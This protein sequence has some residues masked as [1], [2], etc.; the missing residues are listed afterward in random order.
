MVLR[1]EVLKPWLVTS[2]PYEH[3]FCNMRRV[4]REFTCLV[5]V[6]LIEK[7]MCHT[8]EMFRVNLRPKRAKSCG[9][10]ESYE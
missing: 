7:D 4:Q 9:Y 10:F 1:S 2:E 6:C 3:G 5:I 8:D